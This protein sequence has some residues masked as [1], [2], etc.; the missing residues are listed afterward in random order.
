MSGDF[1]DS[2]LL[3]YMYDEVDARKRTIARDLVAVALS[4]GGATVSFQVV[5]ETLRA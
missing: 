2:N 4:D 1:L 5:Q 3:I